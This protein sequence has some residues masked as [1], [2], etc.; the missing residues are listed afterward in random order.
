M[1][2]SA[3]TQHQ[4]HTFLSGLF[5]EDLHAKRVLSLSLATLGVIHATSLSVYAIGQALAMARGTQGKHGIKQVDRLLS[6]TGI[7][8]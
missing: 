2:S 3:I 5:E 8:V 7:P 6:N 1:T 4:V